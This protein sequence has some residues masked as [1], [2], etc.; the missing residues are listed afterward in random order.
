MAVVAGVV[1]VVT[2]GAGL[3]FSLSR[4]DVSQSAAPPATTG[5]TTE[6][7][8]TT[9]TTSSSPSPT[10]RS[11]SPT[12]TAAPLAT[13]T[14]SVAPGGDGA[15]PDEPGTSTQPGGPAAV[16]VTYAGWDRAAEQVQVNAFVS[17]LEM[18]G[19]CTLTVADAA[20]A[21]QRTATASA[22]ADATTTICDQLTL[23]STT[24]A[25]GTWTATVTYSSPPHQGRSA[26][27]DVVVTR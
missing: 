1:V 13:T 18:G 9:T 4:G 21:D 2:G 10:A 27:S 3:A 15:G 8:T 19:S 20:G 12:A 26:A 11:D 23:D 24:M 25:S 16:S 14:T 17:V 7:P 5:G 6:V 22:S